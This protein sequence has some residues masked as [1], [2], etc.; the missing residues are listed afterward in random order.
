MALRW[1]IVMRRKSFLRASTGLNTADAQLLTREF[2]APL[3]G[4]QEREAGA[5]LTV[6]DAETSF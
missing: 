1:S 5:G 2:N 3:W 4:H 6:A